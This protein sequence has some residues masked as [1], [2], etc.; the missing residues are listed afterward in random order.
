[1]RNSSFICSFYLP[2]LFQTAGGFRVRDTQGEQRETEVSKVYKNWR[3][4]FL[5]IPI[6]LNA[7]CPKSFTRD[8]SEM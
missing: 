2:F 7:H 4:L 3:K 1:M 6:H 8:Y 5:S